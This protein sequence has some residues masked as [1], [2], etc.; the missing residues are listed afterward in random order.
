MEYEFQRDAIE[1]IKKLSDS[2]HRSILIE[3]ISGSGKTYIAKMYRK[4]CNI[5]D[6]I[7]IEPNVQGVREAINSYATI[8]TPAVIC[9]ENLDS[10]SSASV[11]AILKFLEEPNHNIKMVITCRS[12][13][14]L[15]DTISSRC[16]V[17]SLS[18]PTVQDVSIYAKTKDISKYEFLL[19][20]SLNSV[21]LS[22]ADI[23]N[24]FNLTTEQISYISGTITNRKGYVKKAINGVL[25]DFTHFEDN[26]E[27]PIE[28]VKLRIRYILSCNMNKDIRKICLNCLDELDA[29]RIANHVVLYKFLIDFTLCDV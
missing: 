4:F 17:V 15:P 21:V 26:S 6:F 20:T 19:H 7:I 12:K 8:K 18:N 2:D 16:M 23:D 28:I 9:V 10:G 22:F 27:I 5:S 13:H 14:K 29:N 1:T 24:I 3:G 11:G 25:W